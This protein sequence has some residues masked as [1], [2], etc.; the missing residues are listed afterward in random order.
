MR[1]RRRTS[2]K[3]VDFR[4]EL[5]RQKGRRSSASFRIVAL[6]FAGGMA[7]GVGIILWP[8]ASDSFAGGAA[9]PRFSV[10]GAVRETCVIDGDTFWL[11]G[12][13]IRI[14]DIDTPEISE[15][16]CDEEYERGIAARDQLV[17]LL[18]E[19]PFELAAIGGRDED[20]YG[21]KLRVVTRESRS[22]GNQLVSE[23]LARTWT[24]RRQPWC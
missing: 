3:V 17:A 1:T 12:E 9:S 22:I 20:Q 14:A 4:D 8:S 23:G 11:D 2:A 5:R 16:R 7:L 24:G 15:P 18:N 21:R 19:G 13:R 10:C 6:G